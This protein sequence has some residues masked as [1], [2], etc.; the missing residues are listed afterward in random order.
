[1]VRNRLVRETISAGIV[2]PLLALT[3]LLML[4]AAVNAYP[5]TRAECDAAGGTWVASG[6]DGFCLKPVIDRDGQDCTEGGGF[7]KDG[8]CVPRNP[9]LLTTIRGVTI[10]GRIGFKPTA[11]PPLRLKIRLGP[12]VSIIARVRSSKRI[13]SRTAPDAAGN[14]TLSFVMV[15]KTPLD[16]GWTVQGMSGFCYVPLLADPG[17]GLPLME[18]C[19]PGGP[20]FL[21]I[22]SP[23]VVAVG[24]KEEGVK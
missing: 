18:A 5:K 10:T 22:A 15:D 8:Y 7:V 17:G 1:M 19:D 6:S 14:F 13:L 24:I 2:I 9:R 12:M 23:T 20:I 16:L 4:P 11:S 21:S 3:G